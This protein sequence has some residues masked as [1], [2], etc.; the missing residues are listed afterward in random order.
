MGRNLISIDDISDYE[1]LLLTSP[2]SQSWRPPAM[3][4][5]TLA[6]LFEQASLRT[7][8]SFAAAATRVGLAPIAITTK[9]GTFRDQC[10]L[11]DEV[12]QLSLT[13]DCVVVRSAI[14]LD[15]SRLSRCAA[16]VVNAGDASN[17]HPTQTLL[18]IAVMRSLGLF[19]KTV[20]IVGNLRDHR[21]AHSLAK[22]LGR[23]PVKLRLVAPNGMAMPNRYVP[24][25]AEVAIANTTAEVDALIDDVDF[26]YLPP[27]RYW[28][29]PDLDFAG[30]YDFNLARAERV[31]KSSARIL[32]PFPRFTELDKSLDGSQFDAYRMQTIMGPA[33][34]ERVLRLMLALMLPAA[35]KPAAA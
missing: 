24:D 15:R 11:Y 25:H 1:L 17:E 5:G 6:F 28:T 13:S 2:E 14:E 8:S 21:S 4:H 33:V 23:L 27:V 35:A 19:G 26:V 9:G 3:T 12:D 29:S 18:D 16:P 32:H 10:N 34:R 20:A 30:A 22:G 7:M 31:L